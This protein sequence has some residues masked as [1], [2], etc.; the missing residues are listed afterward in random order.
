MRHKNSYFCGLLFIF[1]IIVLTWRS[2]LAEVDEQ[3]GS[4]R[5]RFKLPK[6]VNFHGFK[7]MF[8]KHY[9]S[10][11]ENM[12]RQKL[13]LRSAICAFISSVSYKHRQS[14]YYLAINQMSDWTQDEFDQLTM[15]PDAPYLKKLSPVRM[16]EEKSFRRKRSLE[17]ERVGSPQ[18]PSTDKSRNKTKKIYQVPGK[19]LI[20]SAVKKTSELFKPRKP[21]KLEEKSSRIE[22]KVIKLEEPTVDETDDKTKDKLF[23]DHRK[24][25]C[26]PEVKNQ[27]RCGCCYVFGAIAIYEWSYCKLKNE[28]VDFAEKY[29]VDCANNLRACQGGTFDEVSTFINEF[30]LELTQD[31]KYGLDWKQQCP[32]PEDTPAQE[33]GLVRMKSD[34]YRGYQHGWIEFILEQKPLVVIQ[35]LTPYYQMYGGGVDPGEDCPLNRGLHTTVLVGHGR[36]DGQEYWLLRN[37]FGRFWGQRGYY[38]LSKAAK[39]FYA[40]SAFA[41]LSIQVLEPS[42]NPHYKGK[43]PLAE[44]RMKYGL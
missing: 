28:P 1:L 2:S 21:T 6:F 42:I 22:Q 20:M 35:S 17:V 30:G 39:C 8:K 31:Y 26:F 11:V 16:E 3:N 9:E 33:M 44:R 29:V 7:E 4:A 32:Y 18:E 5:S 13:F 10:A 38:K 36:E 15:K 23:V 37:S 12:I 24:S 43:E 19:S 34:G 27:G 14:S 40:D 25:G 41:I